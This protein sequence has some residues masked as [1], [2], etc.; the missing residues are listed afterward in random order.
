MIDRNPTE[1]APRLWFELVIFMTAYYPLFLILLILDTDQRP[2]GIEIGPLV[3]GYTIS[4][5]ALTLFFLSSCSVLI[6][7]KIMRI[8]LTYQEGGT[9][10]NIKS[11]KQLRGDIL[12]YTLPFL[13]GL[14]AFDYKQWQSITALIVFLSFMFAFVKADRVSLLNPMF[15]LLGIRLYQISYI[16]VGTNPEKHK[17]VLCLGK[18]SPSD[19]LI[20]VK[21]S[22]GIEF[23]YPEK[24]Q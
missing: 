7:S 19:S 2:A 21:Q 23:I 13:I 16:Q 12:I 24:D 10:I 9:P 14:F 6:S 20:Y 22:V 8:N 11:V 17:T 4:G 3:W 18:L 15:L 1:V 5:W